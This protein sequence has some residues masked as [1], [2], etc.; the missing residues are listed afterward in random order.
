MAGSLFDDDDDAQPR[1]DQTPQP[2]SAPS[3]SAGKTTASANPFGLDDEEDA[4]AKG[5][6]TRKTG[7]KFGF[8]TKS[9]KGMGKT[10]R[11]NPKRT[12]IIGGIIFGVLLLVMFA[13]GITNEL[14]NKRRPQEAKFDL[15]GSFNIQE[16]MN[17]RMDIFMRTNERRWNEVQ[18]SIKEQADA[19]AK[20]SRVLDD[21]FVKQEKFNDRQ[22]KRTT[23]LEERIVTVA[24]RPSEVMVLDGLP[25]VPVETSH[26]AGFDAAYRTFM[27]N[28]QTEAA[29][30][31]LTLPEVRLRAQRFATE[32]QLVATQSADLL[33]DALN[34][35]GML[36]VG[37]VTE[38]P[39]AD[40]DRLTVTAA[41]RPF[42][43]QAVELQYALAATD[44]KVLPRPESVRQAVLAKAGAA[45][46]DVTPE[47]FQRLAV[48]AR[49][50]LENV[51]A[52]QELALPRLALEQTRLGLR[53]GDILSLE[54]LVWD[55]RES[56]GNPRPGQHLALTMALAR[57]RAGIGSSALEMANVEELQMARL[58]GQKAID[59]AMAQGVQGHQELIGRAHTAMKRT[60]ERFRKQVTD[61][62]L[63]AMALEILAG[64]IKQTAPM[65]A[66]SVPS[67][68][69]PGQSG[70][71][72]T[73][74]VQQSAD[75]RI[76][77]GPLALS[78]ANAGRA[79]LALVPRAIEAFGYDPR[80]DEGAAAIGLLW[81]ASDGVGKESFA[82]AVNEPLSGKVWTDLVLQRFTAIAVT[83]HKLVVSD[84]RAQGA[85]TE[86]AGRRLAAIFLGSS[87]G[88]YAQDFERGESALATVVK[89]LEGQA[90]LG[91]QQMA[92]LEAIPADRPWEYL[93]RACELLHTVDLLTDAASMERL[94]RDSAIWMQEQ[95]TVV[96]AI[97]GHERL[98][99]DLRS[100]LFQEVSEGLYTVAPIIIGQ[101]AQPYQ[102]AVLYR[103]FRSQGNLYAML[104]VAE[105]TALHL[106]LQ[107]ALPRYLPMMDTNTGDAKRLVDALQRAIPSAVQ[108]RYADVRIPVD[109]TN[110]VD[111]GVSIAEAIAPEL[112]RLVI[113]EVLHARV[114]PRVA[115]EAKGLNP[116]V[117]NQAV[118]AVYAASNGFVRGTNVGIND[119]DRMA[120]ALTRIGLDAVKAAQTEG[121]GVRTGAPA[122]PRGG[123]AR[124]PPAPVAVLQLGEV[125]KKDLIGPP[126]GMRSRTLGGKRVRVIPAFSFAGAV[127][128]GGMA[129]EISGS[130]NLP[131]TLECS[132]Q[133]TGPGDF[134]MDMPKLFVGGFAKPVA[135]PSRISVELKSLS[136]RF[137]DGRMI[138]KPINGF[139]VDNIQ[140]MHGLVAEWHTNWEKVLPPALAAGLLKGSAA[141]LDSTGQTV[142]VTAG[143]TTTVANTNSG[144]T[145]ERALIGGTSEAATIVGDYFRQFMEKVQPTVEAPNGQ[146]VTVIIFEPIVFDEVDE[147]QWDMMGGSRNYAGF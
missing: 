10:V 78:E 118:Q 12:M 69:S 98:N 25:S 33:T 113:R 49:V 11:R 87:L 84:V 93:A 144:S 131:I 147:A 109:D 117:L 6:D 108:D 30:G 82:A 146:P 139:V 126:V 107:Q 61:V 54:A 140:G 18:A 142:Q 120:I 5:K 9:F 38:S 132:P 67:P 115:K 8:D 4:K 47:Q 138:H 13:I 24:K 32:Q 22:A 75:R 41:L 94:Q 110:F 88:P 70:Q 114:E 53:A 106:S 52:D 125:A 128:L 31:R 89:R 134:S 37:E 136:Y 79:A 85:S 7:K 19:N 124:G 141:A 15:A 51:T 46:K 43:D 64:T 103:I 28:L 63:D 48:V 16:D 91:V 97:K 129:P 36:F 45:V 66:G 105:A 77:L 34:K 44:G 100:K 14:N 111:V 20:A 123:T 83:A 27:S 96:V 112:E 23:E 60:L 86:A 2:D 133:W 99:P 76:H 135:G 119:M 95:Q 65:A 80:T 21:Y 81:S 74:V 59:T 40:L 55:Q 90:L 101:A 68:V 29:Q 130:D 39:I 73:V 1:R 17:E 3:E 72:V 57:S 137:P 71:P 104:S 145:L 56:L 35:T 58:A 121:N 127:V 143:G 26:A 116:K 42:V 50:R 92:E 102:S 122:D 62:K